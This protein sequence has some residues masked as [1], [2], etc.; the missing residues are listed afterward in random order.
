MKST[1]MAYASVQPVI[2]ELME[3]VNFKIYQQN[4]LKTLIGMELYAFVCR[5]ML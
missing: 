1:S 3:F 2:S 4:V 5:V